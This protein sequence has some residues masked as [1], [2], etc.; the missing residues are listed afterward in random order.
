MNEAK[1]S[2]A[3]R[4]PIH[5]NEAKAPK[6]RGL[7]AA[8]L[9]LALAA[10]LT[11]GLAS[12]AASG[13]PTIEEGSVAVIDSGEGIQITREQFD[14]TGAQLAG[15]RKVPA[16]EDEQYQEFVDAVM[17]QVLQ[18]QWF[19]AE[20][21][22][23]GVEVSEEEIGDKLAEIQ[24]V[25]FGEDAEEAQEAFEKAL[26]EGS[27][28]TEEELAD[29]GPA[30]CEEARRQAGLVSLQEKLLTTTTLAGEIAA[31]PVKLEEYK[32]TIG[33]EEV[34]AFYEE[35]PTN[36]ARPASRDAR[37][38]LN[39]DE[40]KVEEALALLNEDS[41]DENWRRVAKEFS[42]DEASKD[43]GGLLESLIEG[44]GE[45]ERDDQIFMAPEGEL[46]GPF[47][48]ERGFYVIQVTEITEPGTL[49][50]DEVLRDQI[51]STIASNIQTEAI[52]EQQALTDKWTARSTCAEGF[53]VDLCSNFVE[54]EPEA[55]PGQPAPPEQPESAPTN[56]TRPIAPGTAVSEASA[57]SQGQGGIDPTTGLPLPGGGSFN[58][59]QQGGIQGPIPTNVDEFIL[60]PAAPLPG[61]VPPGL[62]PGAIPPGAVPPGGAPPGAVPP[63][64]T[65]VPT[66]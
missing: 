43:R 64:A 10:A 24:R 6:R 26:I 55:I 4:R 1:T 59:A 40:A 32:A 16:P 48:T 31:D 45:P 29:E 19:L 17:S 44:Q 14:R 7:V 28:C 56:S 65:P 42:E 39:E 54:P 27:F 49:P 46:V 12:G 53:I 34:E 52:A 62:P 23:Q 60:P 51:R 11:I 38:I 2:K 33:D 37:V 35:N 8:V 15:G 30:G 21:E 61:G 50:L 13:A 47:E 58:G 9:G 36:F 22:E 25:S 20:A 3:S 63:G 66:P 41:S 5:G 57:I 18:E